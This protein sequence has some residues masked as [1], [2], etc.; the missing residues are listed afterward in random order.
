MRVDPARVHATFAVSLTSI[1]S[2]DV[3]SL[4]ASVARTCGCYGTRHRD[5]VLSAPIGTLERG[6]FDADEDEGEGE[7]EGEGDG[8]G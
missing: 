8:E 3:P 4:P 7:G 1:P 2:A 6:R 5:A